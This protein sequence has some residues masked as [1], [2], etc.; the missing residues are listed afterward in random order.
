ME[1]GGKSNLDDK[2][3]EIWLVK[4]IIMDESTK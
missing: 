2:E 3:A 4:S 1:Y